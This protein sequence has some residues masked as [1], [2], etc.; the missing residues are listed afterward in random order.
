MMVLISE[1]STV[2]VSRVFSHQSSQLSHFDFLLVVT[3]DENEK[4]FGLFRFQSVDQTGH[5]TLE[6]HVGV[7]QFFAGENNVTHLLRAFLVEKQ[8]RQSEFAPP[9][10]RL[11]PRSASSLIS[12]LCLTAGMPYPS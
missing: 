9:L 4:H 3:R 7:H 12:S 2:V 10:A 6:V 11:H 5:G 1:A 8:F